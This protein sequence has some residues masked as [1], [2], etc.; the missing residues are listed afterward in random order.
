MVSKAVM[1]VSLDQKIID[2]I[3]E[4]AGLTGR[5]KSAVV[6][7]LITLGFNTVHETYQSMRGAQ[8]NDQ[9]T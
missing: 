7:E 9:N 1:A 3:G 2:L 6:T 4:Y 5:T 8:D